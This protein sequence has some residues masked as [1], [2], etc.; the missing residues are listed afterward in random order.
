MDDKLKQLITTFHDKFKADEAPSLVAGLYDDT[1]I[2]RNLPQNKEA[3]YLAYSEY[4]GMLSRQEYAMGGFSE[5]WALY[6]LLSV[7]CSSD[8][9]SEDLRKC[10]FG[11]MLSSVE[12]DP[13]CFSV[14]ELERKEFVALT[15]VYGKVSD[16]FLKTQIAD[17]L[18]AF[19]D[20]WSA[21]KDVRQYAR[22]ALGS[23]LQTPI[24]EFNWYYC[25][26]EKRLYRAAQLQSAVRPSSGMKSLEL[27]IQD[28]LLS[29][30][31]DDY[32][33]TGGIVR[34]V[35][36]TRLKIDSAQ[37]TAIESV[38]LA[39]LSRAISDDDEM[40]VYAI[41]TALEQWASCR[42]RMVQMD[43]VH[44][45]VARYLAGKAA[46]LQANSSS[47]LNGHIAG[48]YSGAISAYQKIAAK[49]RAANGD[50]RMLED[51]RKGLEKFYEAFQSSI[52]EKRVP[53]GPLPNYAK[54]I[55]A[56]LEHR[57]GVEALKA[58]L[59]GLVNFSYDD[60]QDYAKAYAKSA[61]AG[62]VFPI[63]FLQDGRRVGS[64]RPPAASASDPT[65]DDLVLQYRIG[66]E[67]Q[68]LT[69]LQPAYH[70]LKAHYHVPVEELVSLC[71][72]STYVPAEHKKQVAMGLY[73]GWSGDFWTAV[74]L[75]SPQVEAIVRKR[76]HDVNQ[77]TTTNQQQC[78][79]YELSISKLIECDGASAVITDQ[80][81]L[82]ELRAL[83]GSRAWSGYC[84][85]L[86]NDIQHGLLKDDDMEAPIL[87]YTWWY[88][89]RQ[90]LQGVKSASGVN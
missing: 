55:E 40:L 15:I 86:R 27:I 8:L 65:K 67:L 79:D 28:S 70:Y 66:V 84:Y 33:L 78:L 63:T 61:E 75:L 1:L 35:A 16:L 71:E 22:D 43:A 56:F 72:L 54:E 25:S 64:V 47:F 80:M 26:G 53:L 62:L 14:L 30:K 34:L 73:Y 10:P 23:Y 83:F 37:N 3:Q 58:F 2:R 44:S 18:W 76:Y 90:V 19:K 7:V 21:G 17:V 6:V 45:Q 57:N 41:Q 11:P 5:K 32:K 36:K 87:M 88:I 52:P 59:L 46:S 82:L 85:N 12:G 38:L 39:R 24:D 60:I 9:H 77:L 20:K 50:D 31:P 42:S 48:L 13:E 49:V 89:F 29:D 74:S 68:T 81:E 69:L 51:A 4:F